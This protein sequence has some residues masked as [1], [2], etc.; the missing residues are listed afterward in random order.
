[1][2]ESRGNRSAALLLATLVSGC[3]FASAVPEA[4]DPRYRAGQAVIALEQD[5]FAEARHELYW[6]AARCEA[7]DLGR[8]ALLL[9]AAAELDPANPYG[10]PEAAA[11]AAAS[12]LL[13]PDADFERLPLARSLYRVAVDLGGSPGRTGREAFADLPPLAGRFDTCESGVETAPSSALPTMAEVTTAAQMRALEEDV[14]L[15]ADSIAALEDRIASSRSRIVELERE[16]ERIMALLRQGV[17]ASPPSDARR[18]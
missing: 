8:D 14:A 5:A 1:M 9:L 7:G 10:S 17:A 12:Y 4:Q 11:R 3:A 6:L 16:I 18:E 2:G 15:R 13:L